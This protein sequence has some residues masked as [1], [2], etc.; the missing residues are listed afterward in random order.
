MAK[1][2]KS[3]LRCQRDANGSTGVQCKMPTRGHT[4]AVRTSP[5]TSTEVSGRRSR[6]WTWCRGSSRFYPFTALR[7]TIPTNE[8]TNTTKVSGVR[9]I[10]TKHRRPRTTS[11]P[12]PTDPA[13]PSHRSPTS[14][15]HQV[16]YPGQINGCIIY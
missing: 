10:A 15:P 8:R 16:I 2:V 3:S 5:T 9:D 12:Q 11:T 4:G 13:S 6:V 1:H 7:Q 14:V